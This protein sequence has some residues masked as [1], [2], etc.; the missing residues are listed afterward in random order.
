MKKFNGINVTP[1]NGKFWCSNCDV[2]D[3]TIVIKLNTFREIHLC[4]WCF[5][6]LK[7]EINNYIP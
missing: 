4:P 5:K 7:K 6:Q 1:S 2:Q 3:A